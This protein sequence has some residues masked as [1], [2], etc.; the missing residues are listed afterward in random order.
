MVAAPAADEADARRRVRGLG[1]TASVESAAPE[2][3]GR[4]PRALARR[5]DREER[6]SCRQRSHGRTSRNRPAR[7]CGRAA[8]RRRARPAARRALAA[9]ATRPAHRLEPAAAAHVRRHGRAVVGRGRV[10]QDSRLSAAGAGRR[11]RAPR[12]RRAAAVDALAGDA[13]RDPARLR[14]HDR[15]GDPARPAD[16]ALAAREADRLSADHADAARAEDRGRAAV[17]RLARLRHRV[18]GAADG[19]DDVLPAA[20]R[21][22]QRLPDPRRPAAVSHEVD[23]RDELA[24][25]P[26]PAL[27]R[28][29]CR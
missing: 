28:R 23:G 13:D 12:D 1:E 10:L 26:L 15:H 19:A 4:S 20:A 18:E 9:R 27:S 8:R 24:D 17:P 21:E 2:E 25:V 11:V 6:A 5:T 7:R 16:R 22:H 14:P 3:H 29:R